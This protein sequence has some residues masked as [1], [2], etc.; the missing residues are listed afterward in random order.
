METTKKIYE[1]L[2]QNGFSE[3][4]LLEK[5]HIIIGLIDNLCHEIVYH[6]HSELK[7]DEMT[8]ICINTILYILNKE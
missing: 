8:N 7:Y 5:S 1:L 4:N 6:K 2:V 3:K